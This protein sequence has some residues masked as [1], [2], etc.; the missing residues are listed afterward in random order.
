MR[1][2]HWTQIAGGGR[3]GFIDNRPYIETVSA[4]EKYVTLDDSERSVISEAADRFPMRITPYYLS[5]ID[6]NDPNDPIRRMCIPS[7]AELDASGSYDTSGEND[8]TVR[9]GIQQKLCEHPHYDL[10]HAYMAEYKVTYEDYLFCRE[11]DDSYKE[12]II[13]AITRSNDCVRANVGND[14]VTFE[15]STSFLSKTISDIIRENEEKEVLS[16]IYGEPMKVSGY[17]GS[18][19]ASYAKQY[20]DSYNS[21]YPHYSADCAN[22]VSQCVYWGGLSMNGS[23]VNVGIHDSTTN[24]YCIYINTILWVRR[25]AVTTSWIRVSDFNA[26]FSSIGTKT[27]KTTIS[28]LVSSCAVGDPVQLADKTTGTA[29]HTIIISEKDSST[30]YFCGHTNSRNNVNVYDYLNQNQDKFILFDIT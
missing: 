13:N 27:T 30:A 20:A 26:Y 8:N 25:Y 7:A 11:A 24:W 19:A 1:I 15:L 28:A 5:L 10:I 23:S 14:E 12:D 22:F 17:S 18:Q 29:Y 6:P 2:K 21:A 16:K 9:D 4:L 3:N